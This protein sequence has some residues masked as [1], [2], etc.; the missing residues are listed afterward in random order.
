MAG[1]PGAFENAL[2]NIRDAANSEE[3]PAK[4]DP[5][6]DLGAK[7]K[8]ATAN[9]KP[10][11]SPVRSL[12]GRRKSGTEPFNHRIDVEIKAYLYDIALANDWTMNRTMREAAKA[13]A[14]SRGDEEG[15]T[16]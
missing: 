4:G 9:P 7:P 13:L 5:A 12:K 6:L 3:G 11:S 2:Q 8:T 16:L 14:K 10:K 1:Q 15:D